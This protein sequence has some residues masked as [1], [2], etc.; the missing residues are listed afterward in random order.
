METN[1]LRI[2]KKETAF[3]EEDNAKWDHLLLRNG[4]GWNVSLRF[5]WE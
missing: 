2:C 5:P 3:G 1:H 4:Y